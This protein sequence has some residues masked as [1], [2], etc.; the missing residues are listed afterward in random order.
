MTKTT[1]DMGLTNNV[2][3]RINVAGLLK[4]PIGAVRRF[5]LLEDIAGIDQHLDVQS[6]LVGSLTLIRTPDG[7]LASASPETSLELECR[8]CLEPFSGPVQLEIEEEF[9]PSVDIGTGARLPVADAEEDAT[10]IDEHHVLD[11]TEVVR[12]AIFLALP[13]SP[14][15]QQDCA[16]LCPLC[17]QNLNEGRCQCATDA[18]DPRLEVLKQLL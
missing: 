17:G 8:R 7:V 5:D 1:L 2:G 10:V 15:C 14:L 3:M 4:G 6:P 13:M 18:V 11:L 16:G 9:H 12:Q